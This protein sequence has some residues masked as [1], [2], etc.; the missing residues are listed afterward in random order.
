MLFLRA[1]PRNLS[2][3]RVN[4]FYADAEPEVGICEEKELNTEMRGGRTEIHRVFVTIQ[5]DKEMN[6]GTKGVLAKARRK[7]TKAIC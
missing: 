6:A 7:A 3:L 4:D 5:A 1:S 2:E